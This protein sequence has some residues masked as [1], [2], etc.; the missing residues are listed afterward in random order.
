MIG[1]GDRMAW[2]Q[3]DQW[4]RKRC[5]GEILV[6]V[7]HLRQEVFHAVQSGALLVVGPD[8]SPRRVSGVRVKEHCLFG[9][10]VIV[11][12]KVPRVVEFVEALPMNATG[13]VVRD[14]LRARAARR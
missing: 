9:L 10:G 8:H 6:G 2:V 12:Y 1:I 14:E 4:V 7:V 5:N 11:P 13:K 3:D